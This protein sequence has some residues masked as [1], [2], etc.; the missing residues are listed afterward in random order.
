MMKKIAILLFAG[1][2][3]FPAM[4]QKDAKAKKVLDATAS[5]LSAMKGIKANF[6][7]TSF[8]GTA[9]QGSSTGTMYLDGKRYRME[10]PELITWFDGKTQWA[11]IPENDEVNVSTPTK[12][13]QQAANPYAFVALY[14]KGYNYTM[15]PTTYNG[16]TVNEVRLTAESS[17]ADIQE[18]RVVISTDNVPYS[19]RIRQ[20]KANWT[21]IRI[22][23]LAG[24]QKFNKDT[25]TFPK[26][27]Y[28]SAEIIDLR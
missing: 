8:N 5:K 20:G 17:S 16:K 19:I 26:D 4:A 14:K 6:E 12:E 21:R 24:K 13:E 2:L 18:A 9:Q 10:S 28:P 23:S 11:Y 1:L 25:F 7:I 15:T 22:S 3:S 27:Q